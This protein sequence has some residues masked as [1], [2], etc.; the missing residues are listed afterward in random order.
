[1][2]WYATSFFISQNGAPAVVI[3]I[4]IAF[5]TVVLLTTLQYVQQ[6][7]WARQYYYSSLSSDSSSDLL[8][9]EPTKPDSIWPMAVV[10]GVLSVFMI[11]YF[12][13]TAVYASRPVSYTHLDVY[14]RQ[15]LAL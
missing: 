10:I 15:T 6:S 4:L 1:M 9:M 5:S 11:A 8:Y 2:S 12:W 14:K 7:L 13:A 3:L